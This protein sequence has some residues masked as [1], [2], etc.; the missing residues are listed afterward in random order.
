MAP[1]RLNT[2]PTRQIQ[3][4]VFCRSLVPG[5]VADAILLHPKPQANFN[6]AFDRTQVTDLAC[7]LLGLQ[8]RATRW[9][10]S[11]QWTGAT[12]GLRDMAGTAGKGRMTGWGGRKEG[13]GS[14]WSVKQIQIEFLCANCHTSRVKF[15]SHPCPP[16]LTEPCPI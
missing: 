4:R 8:Q 13:A 12:T 5:Y 6:R 16:S 1:P 15:S 3:L 7:R 10:L 2:H 9:S 11:Y 14:T